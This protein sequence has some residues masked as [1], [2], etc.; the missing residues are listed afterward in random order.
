MK[1][2]SK[3]NSLMKLTNFCW[4]ALR[5]L[6]SCVVGCSDTAL[7]P[8]EIPPTSNPD[9]TPHKKSNQSGREE[10]WNNVIRKRKK[11]S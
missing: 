9:I 2:L 11:E 7:S 6:L 10:I 1:L 3:R 5:R 8:C 4:V